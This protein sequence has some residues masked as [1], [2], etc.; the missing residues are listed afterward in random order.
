[1]WRLPRRERRQTRRRPKPTPLWRLRFDC[2]STRGPGN[3]LTLFP[4]R[5]APS[6]KRN[7]DP[8]QPNAEDVVA[9]E[10]LVN[11]R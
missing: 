4:I 10:K 6:A 3:L 8:L 9:P 7:D 2:A 1:M 11:R 5:I